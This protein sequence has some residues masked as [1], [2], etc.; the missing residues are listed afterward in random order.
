MTARPPGR[1]V[2]LVD[3]E[4]DQVEMYQLALEVAGYDVIAAYTGEDGIA[5]ARGH[6]PDAIVL[7]VRLPDI[8]GW[9]VCAVLRADARTERIPVIILTAA[10]VPSIAEQAADAGCAACL[11]KPCFPDQLIRTVRDVI[12]AQPQV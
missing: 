12:A 5:R 6:T 1:L 10:A 7:D 8:S 4:A 3:D 2:L 9:E 11:L